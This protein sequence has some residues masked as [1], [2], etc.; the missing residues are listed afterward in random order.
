MS[1]IILGLGGLIHSLISAYIWVVIIAAVLSWVRPDPSN[2][3]VQILYRVTEPAYQL[4]RRYIPTT[5][6]GID[7]TPLILIIGLQI[8]D[9]VFVNILNAMVF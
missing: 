6:N 8:I 4:V 1:G 9:I 2:P 5:F 7:F 3:I